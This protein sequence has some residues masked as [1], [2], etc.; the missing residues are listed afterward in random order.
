VWCCPFVNRIVTQNSL[1]ASEIK[2]V[3]KKEIR[4]SSTNIEKR[5][6]VKFG[7]LLKPLNDRIISVEKDLATKCSVQDVKKTPETYF[8]TDFEALSQKFEQD[9]IG[10][11]V[12]CPQTPRHHYYEIITQELSTAR[13]VFPASA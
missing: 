1:S 3:I 5:I 4:S 7:K 13:C 10:K 12:S 9:I 6:H 2:D 11:L 8:K